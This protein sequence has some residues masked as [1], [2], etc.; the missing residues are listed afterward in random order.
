MPPCEDTVKTQTQKRVLTHWQNS[1]S[2]PFPV[3]LTL[4]NKTAC[5]ERTGVIQ[6]TAA[7][8][9]RGSYCFCLGAICPKSSSFLW[10][11]WGQCSHPARGLI[12]Q[13][14]SRLKRYC[15]RRKPL[16]VGELPMPI[17]GG[18]LQTRGWGAGEAL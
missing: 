5:Y 6:G 8:L 18:I 9:S 15:F 16:V 17:L 3:D 11:V 4:A 7:F 12:L 1:H 13:R 2:V 14:A 10:K